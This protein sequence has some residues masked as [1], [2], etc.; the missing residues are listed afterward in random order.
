M[1]ETWKYL[2]TD[3]L[4]LGAGGAGLCAILHLMN[5][6]PKPQVFLAVRGLF[7]KSGCTR[8][9]QGGYNVVLDKSD[10]LEAH[11]HDTI[12]GGQWLNDQELAWKMVKEAPGRILELEN[13]AGCFFDR[14][15][16]GTVNQKPFAGQSFDRT[17]HKGDLT[18]IEIINRLSEQVAAMENVTI[19]EEMRAVDLLFDRSGQKVTGALLIDLRCGEFIV[20]QARAVLLATGGGPTMYKITAPCQDKTCDG[21][22]MGFRA[23]A[24]LMDMEMVQFHPTGLLAGNSMISGTVLEEGLR[25][26]GAYLI[27]GKGERYMHRYDPREE[28]AT[29]DVVSRSSFMEI[30]AGRGT[31]EGGIYLDASHLGA[32]FVMKNF[33]GMSL[34]CKDVGYDLPNTPVIVSPTAHFIMGG[35]RIEPDCRT[36]LEGLFAAGEDAAGVHGA[37]RL[38]GNGVAESTVFGGIAGDV[39]ADYLAGQHSKPV[40]ESQ[41][42]KMIESILEPFERKPSV[43]IYSL[44]DRC[45]QSMWENAGLVRNEDSLQKAAD[46]MNEIREQLST[47]SL[48][49]GG[50]AFHLEWMEYL[51]ILNYL[52][53][54]DV[55]IRSA[56][57][58]KESR[59]S[60]FRSDFPDKENNQPLYNI[61]CSM[62]QKLQLSPVLMT[63]MK[64]DAS[65]SV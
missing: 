20:V 33:R 64:T 1:N 12:K 25:G 60:H 9:V 32:E 15:P 2:E 3:V 52:D 8:M 46:D 29:R 4:I 44:R 5:H 24:T 42:R 59:G 48:T 51:S 17:V 28:R 16:D 62:N 14:N 36:D 31:P 27:N 65:E 63:R 22:A 6:H 21:I 45:K 53:V 58:R 23:G 13:R 38:G 54:C 49:Q 18:G 57:T 61:C 19:R 34:R 30:M 37:N 55:I 10:S 39:I 7:G 26:A 56:Q 35:L 43:S 47:I 50:R 41:I 11:F 40:Q